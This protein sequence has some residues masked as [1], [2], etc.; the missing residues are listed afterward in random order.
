MQDKYIISQLH[1]VSQRSVIEIWAWEWKIAS[2]DIIIK[3]KN[4]PDVIVT[5]V[6]F[7]YELL[8]IYD[9]HYLCRLARLVWEVHTQ[10][11]PSSAPDVNMRKLV[12][13]KDINLL[14][15]EL[16]ERYP[17]VLSDNFDIIPCIYTSLGSESHIFEKTVWEFFRYAEKNLIDTWECHKQ[18]FLG[19][20]ENIN[21]YIYETD[22][23]DEECYWDFNR[24]R[25]DRQ[26]YCMC[27][28][29]KI[30]KYDDLLKL[31]KIYEMSLN[32]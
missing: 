7:E 31:Y 14:K 12:R 17:E 27:I 24:S 10:I 8:P 19:T 26:I 28:W 2:K 23:I 9:H 3:Y 1:N 32:G 15:W 30:V 13:E 11:R 18:D 21:E 4:L 25:N 29:W 5:F 20:Y 22:I 6:E 16:A